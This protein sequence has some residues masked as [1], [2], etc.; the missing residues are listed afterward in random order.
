MD[1]NGLKPTKLDIDLHCV[2]EGVFHTFYNTPIFIAIWGHVVADNRISANDWTVKADPDA[3]MFPLQLAQLLAR[4]EDETPE[5]LQNKGVFLNN[6]KFGLHGPVEVVSRRGMELYAQLSGMCE[7]DPDRPPQEDVYLQTCMKNLGVQQV[8]RF[9]LLV[10]D[11][12]DPP[13]GWQKC[14]SDH[15]VFHPFK[16][17]A[18][19]Q[20]C[21]TNSN[22]YHSTVRTE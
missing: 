17:T 13:E 11:H 8:D 4:V 2:K 20:E 6:C 3:V 5:A 16:T 1:L 22:T 14:Q 15:V 19:Y 12:C 10:E 7:N 9:N 21:W 18:A